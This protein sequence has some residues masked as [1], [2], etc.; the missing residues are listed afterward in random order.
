MALTDNFDRA[1]GAL[2]ANW[3]KEV[4][5]GATTVAIVSNEIEL[6]TAWCDPNTQ[7]HIYVYNAAQPPNDC[8][9]QIAASGG[10]ASASTDMGP[11]LRFTSGG[12]GSGYAYRCVFDGSSQLQRWDAGVATNIGNW[13][14]AG[15]TTASVLKITATGTVVAGLVDGVA[16]CSAIDATYASGYA[17]FAYRSYRA[18]ANLG[19][20]DN[21]EATEPVAAGQPTIKRFGGLPH[22][23]VNRG[24]W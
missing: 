23:A 9:S 3:T 8:Y 1:N 5:G 17:G 10:D 16:Q 11:V 24:V 12:N 7:R 19:E 6:D 22:V 15:V 13:D 20:L 18:A 21:W 2:G 14:A 4:S